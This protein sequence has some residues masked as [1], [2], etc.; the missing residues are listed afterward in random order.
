MIMSLFYGLITG[1]IFGFLLQKGQVLRY[2]KQLG[3]MRLIDFTIVKFMLST[4]IVGMIGI[5]LLRDIGAVTLSVK[6][7]N[8]GANI[9]GGVIFGVG[10]AVLGYCPGTAAGALGEGRWDALFGILGML[11]GAAI[12]AELYPLMKASILKWGSLGKITL[13]VVLGMNAWL[14]IIP[15]GLIYMGLFFFFEKKRL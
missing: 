14:L 2:D 6:S 9:I 1:I 12:Y 3:A 4:I 8:I 11:L 5:Y 15:L 7:T 13:P 10:W